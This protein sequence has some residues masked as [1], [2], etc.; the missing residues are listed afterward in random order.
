[1]STVTSFFFLH[2]MMGTDYVMRMGI[3]GGGVGRGWVVMDKDFRR[4]GRGSF[5]WGINFVYHS[6]IACILQS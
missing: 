2:G 1:M 4:V 5:L 6:C 3:M